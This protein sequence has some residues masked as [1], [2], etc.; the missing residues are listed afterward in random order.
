MKRSFALSLVLG[1]LLIMASC[2]S[3]S[4]FKVTLLDWESA[5]GSVT[6]DYRASNLGSTDLTSYTIIFDVTVGGSVRTISHT[7]DN[8][9]LSGVIRTTSAT[10]ALNAGEIATNVTIRNFSSTAL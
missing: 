1:G 5:P 9:L 6:V 3:S 10:L 2:S 7:D 8:D 4:I